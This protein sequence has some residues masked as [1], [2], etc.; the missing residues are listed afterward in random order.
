[1]LDSFDEKFN[2]NLSEKLIVNLSKSELGST[3]D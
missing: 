3:F 1:M 2:K